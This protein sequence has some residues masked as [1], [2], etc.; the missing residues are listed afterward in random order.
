MPVAT[1]LLVYTPEPS[2][3]SL[4][5]VTPGLPETLEN[6]YLQTSLFLAKFL[7]LGFEPHLYHL[8][9]LKCTAR[10]Y[11]TSGMETLFFDLIL[12]NVDTF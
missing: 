9:I 2:Y 8:S 12:V 7:S 10:V 5:Q 11:E 1:S 3:L 6:I 4:D